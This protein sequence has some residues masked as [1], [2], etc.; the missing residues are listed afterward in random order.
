MSNAAAETN[1]SPQDKAWRLSVARRIRSARQAKN[2]TQHEV[3]SRLSLTGNT[4]VYKWESGVQVPQEKMLRRIAEVFGFPRWWLLVSD[5]EL[6]EIKNSN[7]SELLMDSEPE[8][9]IHS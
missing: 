6:L 8:K 2:W 1:E 9:L 7:P 4:T 3:A 5:E